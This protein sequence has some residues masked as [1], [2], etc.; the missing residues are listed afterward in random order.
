VNLRQAVPALVAIAFAATP[1]LAEDKDVVTISGWS[2]NIFYVADDQFTQDDPTTAKDEAQPTAFIDANASLKMAWTVTPR[3]HAKVNLWLFNSTSGSSA[4]S[5]N[6]RESFISYDL[7]GGLTWLMGKYIDH[8]GWISA[9][10]TGLYRINASN[11]GYTA[12]FYGNDVV[13]TA[14]AFGKKDCPISG[15]FHV[16]NGYFT[17]A[18]AS[19]P[20][21]GFAGTGASRSGSRE[22]ADL[23]YGLDLVYAFSKDGQDSINLEF[24]DDPHSAS[25]SATPGSRGG[26]VFQVGLNATIKDVK[27]LTLGGEVIYRDTETGRVSDGA[28]GVAQD[29]GTGS[30]DLGWMLLGNYSLGKALVVPSS[31][32]LSFQQY[33]LNRGDAAAAISSPGGHTTF[34]DVAVALLTNPLENTNFGLNAEVS[35]ISRSIKTTG[36]DDAWVGSIEAIAVIP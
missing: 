13:G 28:R 15:S 17:A 29:P 7:G 36:T 1:A 12:Y 33:T 5:L 16:T 32:T 2:D 23:G 18:D 30:R 14:L 27:N 22:N 24:A 31:V 34:T 25:G 9:E 3:L 21:F 6:M 8:I 4:S 35:Y 11:I 19:N 20:G 10:P 26:N